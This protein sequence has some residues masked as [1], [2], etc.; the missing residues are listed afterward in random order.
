MYGVRRTCAETAALSLGTNHQIANNQP[1]SAVSI[2]LGWL[3]KEMKKKKR[4]GGNERGTEKE[5]HRETDRQ[6]D[7]QTDRDR[8]RRRDERPPQSLN[9]SFKIVC[10]KAQGLLRSKE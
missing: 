1:N 3:F 2:P 8:E 10:D 9:Y 7:R 5:R 4:G 6:T